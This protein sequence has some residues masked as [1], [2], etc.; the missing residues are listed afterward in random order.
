MT[1][2]S[3]NKKDVERVYDEV[4]RRIQLITD[5]GEFDWLSDLVEYRKAMLQGV[6]STLMVTSR[7]WPDVS[8]WCREIEERYDA[9]FDAL[10][11]FKARRRGA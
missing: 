4:D 11:K 9:D 2:V 6:Y 3:Y 1:L 8:S 7:N 10:E 5:D